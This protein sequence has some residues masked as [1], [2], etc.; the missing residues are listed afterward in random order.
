MY[1]YNSNHL[2]PSS[3]SPSTPRIKVT[4]D[5]DESA[6]V[7]WAAQIL[8]DYTRQMQRESYHDYYDQDIE[9]NRDSSRGE[10]ETEEEEGDTFYQMCY[11]PIVLACI[12]LGASLIGLV[13]YFVE[14]KPVVTTDNPV[15]ERVTEAAN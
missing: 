15:D 7:A 1:N 8:S 6:K 9:E 5:I 12:L 2:A 11:M 14:D 4:N 10:E 3:I 13:I